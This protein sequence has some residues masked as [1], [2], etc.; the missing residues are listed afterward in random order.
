MIFLYLALK[1]EKN[2]IYE[3]MTFNIFF[4]TNTV[5]NCAKNA[6][7]KA[8]IEIIEKLQLSQHKKLEAKH[9]PPLPL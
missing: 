4:L 3:Y 5:K 8:D 1:L 9:P 7:F 2:A 6:G